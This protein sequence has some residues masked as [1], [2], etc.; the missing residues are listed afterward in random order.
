MSS[1]TSEPARFD[2]IIVGAG[3]GGLYAIYR[4]RQL[5]LKLRVFEAGGDI[6]GTWY[7]NRYPGCRCD[8][9]SM[10]YSYSFSD[11]LQQEWHWPERYGTQPE[12][13]RY[14]NHVAGR[15]DLRRDI[16]F[17]T[18]VKQAVFDSKTNTWTVTTDK[19]DVATARF[20]IM[21]TG[22]LSTPRTP[23]YPGL[24]SFQ[25]KWYHTGLW[26]HQGVDFTGLRV[27][28]IGTGSSGV[29]SIPIIARQ[30]KHL[31]V[32]QRTA[33]FTLP[34]RNALLDPVK[35]SA[36][37]AH[38]A[39]RRRAAFDTPFGIAGYPP[40]VKSALAATR[41]ERHRLYE[42][43]WAD[44]GSISFLYSFTDLLVN[45][46]SN[47]T[48]A[49]FVRRKIRATVKDPRTA[50]LLCPNDH[51]I[52]T[53][54]LILDTGYYETYN[55]D[56]VTLVDIRSRPIQ[57]I[58]PTGLRTDDTEYAL[59]AIVFAT[60]F[61]AMTGA[62]KEIDIRTDQGW[63]IREKWRHGPRTYLGIMVAGFPNLF[64][65]TGPQS[66]GV[67]SQ[68]ILACEQHVDWIADCLRSLRDHGYARI[69]AEQEAEEAWVRHNNEVADRTLYPLANSWYVGAN[70]PGKPRVF[71]PYVGGVAAYKKTCDEVAARG[72]DGFRFGFAPDAQRFAA[73]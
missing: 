16:A 58:L 17:N 31:Y 55:R 9:E 21:A 53:K 43:K 7:W 14:I 29:Q 71:M 63:S 25:G 1:C 30:A 61:D 56:N 22:N 18:R 65:I 60:G 5:G 51:P 26:P 41:G 64:M 8:V 33:N 48:A 45:K 62:M 49:E 50:E 42:T 19:G 37:K 70:I 32:F 47:N 72:Y 28:V 40:P 38:Y 59:D 66:P 20:C 57:K 36:H 15:F 24:E 52:G 10:E 4:L 73:D 46:D 11:E 44:G 34:A 6:G 27:G 23:D 35:E 12:I 67:K 68:M 13:L 69:E 54:R 3:V 39:E 2:A